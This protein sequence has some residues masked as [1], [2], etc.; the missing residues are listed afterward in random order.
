MRALPKIALL[1]RT[2]SFLLPACY[3]YLLCSVS[4]IPLSAQ[5]LTSSRQWDIR[6]SVGVT[7]LHEEAYTTNPALIA[8]IDSNATIAL[9]TPSRFGIK[10][11]TTVNVGS[12]HHIS[13]GS[14]LGAGISS[15]GGSLYSELT[16]SLYYAS[17]LTSSFNA[18]VSVEYTRVSIQDYPSQSCLNVNA[19]ITMKLSPVVTA[20]ASIQNLTRSALAGGEQTTPQRAA[21]GVGMKL[22]PD[23]FVDAD[24]VITLNRNTGFRVA[25]RYDLLEQ[26]MLRAAFNSEPRSAELSAILLPLSSVSIIV[27]SHYHDV[28]GFSYSGGARYTW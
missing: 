12:F 11:L 20:G 17:A 25:A 8:R 22:M 27:Q 10:E 7:A 1:Y 3:L 9:F 16:A 5:L 6:T 18:G 14:T 24:A 4:S 19:G 15:L 13:S 23:L 28:L 2:A 21:F 26:L